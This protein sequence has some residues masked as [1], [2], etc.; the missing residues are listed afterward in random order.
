[1]EGSG[2][3]FID[4]C[5]LAYEL[6][7][8]NERSKAARNI[9]Y[10]IVL[11]SLEVL[12]ISLIFP[13]LYVELSSAKRLPL[14]GKFLN[15][16]QSVE[17]T[18]LL[19]LLILVFV[20]KNSVAVIITRKQSTFLNQLYLQYSEKTFHE[21]YNSSFTEHL[22]QNS[23]EAF[24]QIKIT[25]YDFT[26]N[27]LNGILTLIADSIITISMASLL[28]WLDYRILF[29]MMLLSAPVI[30]LYYFFRKNVIMKI[31]KS[32][33]ELTPKANI[34]LSQGI[35]SFVE[36][37]IYKKE[38][39]FIKEF[40]GTISI[41]NRLLANLKNFSSL[42]SRIFEILGILSFAAVI[43][44]SKINPAYNENLLVIFGLLAL[45]L[46]KLIPSL[47]KILVSLS[48]IQSFAY[49]IQQLKQNIQNQN[50]IEGK[51]VVEI[52]F[53]KQIV[54]D[55]VSF[56]YLENAREKV[57]ENISLNFSKGEFVLLDGP[58]GSGKTTFIHLVSGLINNYEGNIFIDGNLLSACSI[59]SWHSQLGLVAQSPIILQ[60]TILNNVAFGES[61]KEID[62]Q[63]ASLA[64]GQAGLSEMI[65]GLPAGLKTP[66]GENGLTLSGGQ[67][68][69]LVLA[70]A[71]YRNPKVLLLDEVTNQLDYENKIHILNSLKKLCNDGTTIIFAS[72]DSVVKSYATKVVH[73]DKGN[74]VIASETTSH[75][76]YN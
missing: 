15:L 26:H 40:I 69:R 68:Q 38:D 18:G 64:L 23:A 76:N 63:R 62:L 45:A 14:S 31:D 58:S 4:N 25:A 13:L 73:L 51:D 8:L 21:Y 2:K 12:S 70:R 52:N 3:S 11:A 57:L 41:S 65:A 27:V 71:L 75:L 50:N 53:E 1:M 72:H 49:S 32:F 46:Y 59:H 20:V 24:R 29:I 9:G 48:Q 37:K 66:V 33:R 55:N 54:L 22:K 30:G 44:Y 28:I 17:W 60:D 47:N 61:E 7:P 43:L 34:V 42:P 19:A 56:K 67:R 6:L 5:V 74:A 16:F 39:Y 36:A 35:S 10:S